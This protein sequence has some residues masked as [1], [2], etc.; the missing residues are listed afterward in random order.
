MS[1]LI[2]Q[3]L[4]SPTLTSLS[5]ITQLYFK[6]STKFPVVFYQN[7]APELNPWVKT[8]KTENVKMQFCVI[9]ETNVGCVKYG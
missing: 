3:S 5:C 7:I 6:A 4:N 2:I 9:R 1:S 8:L